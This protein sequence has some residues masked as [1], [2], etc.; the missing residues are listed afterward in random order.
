MYSTVSARNVT[1]N[2]LCCILNTVSTAYRINEMV[3]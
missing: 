3:K 2:G 1:H